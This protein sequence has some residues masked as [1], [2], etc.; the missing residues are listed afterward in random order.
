[1]VKNFKIEYLILKV[2]GYKSSKNNPQKLPK[3][4]TYN[5][6]SKR[7]PQQLLKLIIHVNVTQ[8][9]THK[10]YSKNDQQTLL[11]KL[12]INLTQKNDPQVLV[13]K[14]FATFTQTLLK[15]VQKD[16]LIKKPL[17]FHSSFS[18]KNSYSQS[19]FLNDLNNLTLY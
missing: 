7:D 2:L 6:C 15:N 16:F 13:R 8:K 14:W 19:Q 3:T 9:M 10:R 4:M 1:M 11:K 18:V 17:H 12:S 5:C